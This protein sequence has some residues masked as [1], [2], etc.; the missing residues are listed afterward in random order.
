MLA[1]AFQ[2]DPVF[3]WCVPDATRR[4][5]ILPTFFRIVANAIAVHDDIH[6]AAVSVR[7]HRRRGDVAATGRRPRR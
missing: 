1:A 7:R 4:A 6:V 3:T 2:D 5:A